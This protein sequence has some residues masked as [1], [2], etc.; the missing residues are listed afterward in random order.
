ME[1]KLPLYWRGTEW[2]ILHCRDAEVRTSFSFRCAR[3]DAGLYKAYLSGSEGQALLGTPIPEGNCLMLNRTL[4]H[5]AM[6]TAGVFPPLR[7]ELVLY[8]VNG[9]TSSAQKGWRFARSDDLNALTSA[10][11]Q[12][13]RNQPQLWYARRPN[14][15]ALAIPW[16]L[17]QEIPVLPLICFAKMKYL[18]GRTFLQF[19]F[20][21][22]GK[23][24][25]LYD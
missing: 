9:T 13:F 6:K 5:H 8:S 16:R 4:T 10:L 1:T 19:E 12:R 22:M 14:G 25:V 20:D 17:G 24:H 21:E 15:F 18:D 2:G 3:P 7:C 23:P 11:G